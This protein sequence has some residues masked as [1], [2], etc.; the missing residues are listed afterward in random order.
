MSHE[1]KPERMEQGAQ[2]VNPA[3]D[4]SGLKKYSVKDLMFMFLNLPLSPKVTESRTPY[5]SPRK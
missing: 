2:P 1:K 5:P 3:D 4:V